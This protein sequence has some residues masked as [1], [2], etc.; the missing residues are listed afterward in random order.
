MSETVTKRKY[1]VSR[2]I[3]WDHQSKWSPSRN[4]LSKLSLQE[5]F[6]LPRDPVES[7]CLIT[8]YDVDANHYQSLVLILTFSFLTFKQAQ[9][10]RVFSVLPRPQTHW[11]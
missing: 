3:E 4:F 8:I 11:P 9:Y 7:N 2:E 10:F 5:A 6:M 1:S